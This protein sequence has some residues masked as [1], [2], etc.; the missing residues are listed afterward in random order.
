MIEERKAL[1]VTQVNL[2]V[3]DVI[4]RDDIL[5]DI[6]VKGELS[7]FKAHS[8]GHMY[9]SLKDDSG[10]I[11]AVM[12]RSSASKL[13]FKPQ[14]GTKVI[15]HGRIGVYERDGQYQLYIDDMQQDGQGD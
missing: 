9:M 8:S 15:A 2:Y 10:V 5:C 12:F 14:N 1:S 13:N 3:K 7:N 11:R 6:L 4:A